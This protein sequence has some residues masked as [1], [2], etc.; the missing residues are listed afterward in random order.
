VLRSVAMLLG[1][2][3]SMTWGENS[4]AQVKAVAIVTSKKNSIFVILED[5]DW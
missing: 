1:R 4:E 2:A 3:R 5:G